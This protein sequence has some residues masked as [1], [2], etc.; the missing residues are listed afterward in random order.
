M[1][2]PDKLQNFFRT[3]SG[4][5]LCFIGTLL[6]Q[7]RQRNKGKMTLFYKV[8]QYLSARSPPESAPDGN[9]G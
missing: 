7:L 5:F 3:F 6:S 2:I 9:S 8:Q 4:L 1:V